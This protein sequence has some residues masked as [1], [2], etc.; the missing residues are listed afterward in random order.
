MV[1]LYLAEALKTFAKLIAVLLLPFCIGSCLSYQILK[2]IDGPE[3]VLPRQK[4]EV[5]VTSLE[6]IL[7]Q[8]GA[9]RK[10]QSL[11]QHFALIYQ[12]TVSNNRRL[13]M[14]IPFYYTFRGTDISANGGLSKFDLLILVFTDQG[15]LDHY[16]YAEDSHNPFFKTLF[17]D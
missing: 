6:D 2:Q 13:A 15:I 14:S 11:N 9:P 17:Q 12:R 1:N 4:L 7:R 16:I 3:V 8:C 5:G 10:I